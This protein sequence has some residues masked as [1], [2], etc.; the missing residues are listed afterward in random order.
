MCQS[1]EVST[2]SDAHVFVISIDAFPFISV[3]MK[4]DLAQWIQAMSHR[5]TLSHIVQ[6]LLCVFGVYLLRSRPTYVFVPEWRLDQNHSSD[7]NRW[8][9][10]NKNCFRPLIT[11]DLD[12]DGHMEI[13]VVTST[14]KLLVL[15]ASVGQQG[16]R[17]PQLPQLKTLNSRQLMISGA[18]VKPLVIETGWLMEYDPAQPR[19]SQV[20]AVKSSVLKDHCSQRPPVLRDSIFLGPGRRSS[21]ISK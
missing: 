12:G 7:T 1:I 17:S 20:R 8:C 16:S 15:E 13:I 6:V 2:D 4:N 18:D 19:R 3:K 21:C 11:T 14:M 5:V 9:S 10:S